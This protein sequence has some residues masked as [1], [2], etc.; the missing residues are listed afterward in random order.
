MRHYN[1]NI[2]AK[3]DHSLIDPIIKECLNVDWTHPS[4]ERHEEVLKA[5][6]MI[7]YPFPVTTRYVF[8][9]IDRRI[10]DSTIPLLNWIKSLF[11][12]HLWIRGE[13]GVL[14]P[15]SS[16]KWHRDKN[17]AFNWHELCTKIHMPIITNPSCFESWLLETG[18]DDVHMEAGTLYWFNHK[19]VHTAYNNGEF[20]RVHVILSLLPENRWTELVEVMPRLKNRFVYSQ[21]IIYS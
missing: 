11:E 13:I 6:R 17:P 5:G 21:Q 15:G 12:D 2:I 8:N 16:L 18:T 7:E 10:L 4:F 19:E 1:Y 20:P 3:A 14:L 9:E